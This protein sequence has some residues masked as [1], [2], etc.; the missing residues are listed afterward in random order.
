MTCR[1]AGPA[2]AAG[3]PA[4][5]TEGAMPDTSPA[6]PPNVARIYDFLLV[7]HE[8]PFNRMGVKGLCCQAVAAAWAKLRAA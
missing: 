3:T 5:S 8:A 2:K 4:A 7:R 6:P 1:T